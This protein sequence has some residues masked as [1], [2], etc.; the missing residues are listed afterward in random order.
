M[1]LLLHGRV[2]VAVVALSCLGGEVRSCRLSGRVRLASE[3]YRKLPG[4]DPV[5]ALVA[6]VYGHPC[7][8]GFQ[9]PNS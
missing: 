6:A 2:A 7:S 1:S 4:T 9:V 5:P 3:E 8:S